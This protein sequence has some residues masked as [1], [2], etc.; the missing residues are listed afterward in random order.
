MTEPYR[1]RTYRQRCGNRF[2]LERSKVITVEGV[3]KTRIDRR[4]YVGLGKSELSGKDYNPIVGSNG[5]TGR[6]IFNRV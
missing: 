6:M 5:G 2:R 4:I 1:T 3:P